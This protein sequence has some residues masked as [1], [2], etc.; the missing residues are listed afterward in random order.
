MKKVKKVSAHLHK[1]ILDKKKKIL[2]GLLALLTVIGLAAGVM[3]FYSSGRNPEITGKAGFSSGL[4]SLTPTPPGTA[5]M[6][7]KNIKKPLSAVSGLDNDVSLGDPSI[8]QV[9]VSIPKGSFDANTQIT[10]TNPDSVPNYAGEEIATLG[11]PIEISSTKPVRL[12]DKATLVMRFDKSKMTS[13]TSSAN[14]RVVYYDGKG[15][16]Y[17]KPISVDMAVGTITFGTYH[18]SIF[19]PADIK[20]EKVIAAKWIHDKA[21]GNKLTGQ[22][23]GVSDK[24]AEKVIALT[25]EKMNITDPAARKK[26]ESALYNDPSYKKINEFYGKADP[27]EVNKQIAIMVGQKIAENVPK[28]IF[29]DIKKEAGEI[30]SAVS[31]FSQAAGYAAEGQY[32]EA[33]KLIGAEITDKFILGKAV[34]IAA[35]VTAYEVE[36]W[37]NAEVEA[38]FLAYKNGASGYFYGYNVDKGDFNAIWDQMRGIRRQLELEA[39][40]KENQARAEAGLQ[41]LT[42]TQAD[43]VREG[44][45]NSFQKQFTYRAEKEDQFAEEETKLK[46]IVDA[47][48]K[49]DFFS[50]TGPAGL[51]HGLDY[52]NKLEVLYHFAEKMMKDTNRFN[53]SDKTGLIMDNAIAVD[54]IVRGARAWLSGPEGK[55]QYAAFLKDRFNISLYPK[56]SDLAGKWNGSLVITNIEMPDDVKKQ[57]QDMSKDGVKSSEGCDFALDPSAMIGKQNPI[58]MDIQPQGENGGNITMQSAG[59]NSNNERTVP[60]TYSEGVLSVPFSD[61]GASGS[62]TMEMSKDGMNYSAAGSMIVNYEAMKVKITGT[63]SARKSAQQDTTENKPTGTDNPIITNPT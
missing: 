2:I 53:L 21:V 9:S 43:A 32:K 37:K 23:N 24:V 5:W 34:V 6:Y 55:K 52:E 16:E 54:D 57:I 39:I 22:L 36:S 47:Y 3:F 17:I 35:K 56:L 7:E 31:A 62:L 38:A 45:K 33:A 25:L 20:D 28:V 42:D 63:I 40:A 11:A 44:V 19:G 12:N 60:F 50:V 1:L 58:T 46:K 30:P 26:V 48:T 15:W 49:A 18:F 10:L 29:D 14:L 8:E 41:P 61:K 13:G 4:P 59:T 27:D 51:D